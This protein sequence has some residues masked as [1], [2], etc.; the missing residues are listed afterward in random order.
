MEHVDKIVELS[1]EYAHAGVVIPYG[2]AGFR[3]K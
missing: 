3:A 2:T 1:K